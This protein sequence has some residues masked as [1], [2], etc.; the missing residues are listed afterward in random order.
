MSAIEVANLRREFR[1]RSGLM[2]Q[3]KHVIAV[4][5]V[6]FD[7]PS[8]G[9][10]GIV[11]E[12]GCGKSTLARLILGLLPPTAGTVLVDGRRLSDLGR[13]ARARLIQP[14]FQDPF[15]SLTPRPRVE[16][17]VAL[18]LAAQGAFARR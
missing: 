14:V 3:Q 9:V 2:A 7:V 1:V 6:T 5:D 15:A 8:G 16:D 12:S 18:P 4:D 13:K 10:L 11:G 17:I